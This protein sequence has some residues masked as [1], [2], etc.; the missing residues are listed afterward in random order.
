VKS[1]LF[2]GT[3]GLSRILVL[4]ALA[5]GAGLSRSDNP[6]AASWTSGGIVPWIGLNGVPSAVASDFIY[7]ESLPAN[8]TAWVETTVPGS[9]LLRFEWG[10]PETS[11]GSLE[12]ELDGIVQSRLTA[13]V[14]GEEQVQALPPGPHTLRWRYLNPTS[15]AVGAAWL[16]AVSFEPGLPAAAWGA[17]TGQPGLTW[18]GGG[19]QLWDISPKPSLT[20]TLFDNQ[21]HISASTA[22][23]GPAWVAYEPYQFNGGFHFGLEPTVEINGSPVFAHHLPLPARRVFVPAGAQRVTWHFRGSHSEQAVFL[24]NVVVIPTPEVAIQEAVDLTGPA[25]VNDASLP[26]TGL[27]SSGAGDDY[28]WVA[29]NP[30]QRSSLQFTTPTA[31]DLTVTWDATTAVSRWDPTI[32]LS[33]DGKSYPPSLT[34]QTSTQ[35]IGPG[36][37]QIT[38]FNPAPAPKTDGLRIY[39]I[40]FT[41]WNTVPLGDA[42]GLPG[43]TFTTG[44][45]GWW[46]GVV[47]PALA[48]EGSSL[49]Q[50]QSTSSN[51]RDSA[52]IE[53]VINGPAEVAFWWRVDNDN[54][55]VRLNLNSASFGTVKVNP[56]TPAA[57]S[58][59]TH[60]I[61]L[62]SGPQ[63]LRWSI[64][65]STSPVWLDQLRITPRA[66]LPL[67]VAA[68]L[69]G[70]A[71]T[72][73]I[74]DWFGAVDS[75]ALS[76]N[77]LIEI[78]SPALG[79]SEVRMS[80][81][82][83]GPGVLQFYWRRPASS[84]F[85]NRLTVLMDQQEAAGLS[86][87][88]AWEK[89]T[90]AIPPG[91]H[92]VTWRM[93]DPEP[94]AGF[95]DAFTWQPTPA[96]LTLAN[97]VDAI[98]VT[99]WAASGNDWFPITGEALTV[100]GTDA[101]AVVSQTNYGN[102]L[103]QARCTGA[104]TL[105]Y[106]TRKTSP[107]GY[108]YA[109]PSL[110]V[111]GLTY[112][113]GTPTTSL[114]WQEITLY[115]ANSGT[116]LL[117][118]GLLSRNTA[119]L[120]TLV[121]DQVS[122]TPGSGTLSLAVA[123]DQPRWSF[124]TGGPRPWLGIATP[125]GRGGHLAAVEM[126]PTDTSDGSWLETT[127]TGPGRIIPRINSPSQTHIG[128]LMD[129]TTAINS[130]NHGSDVPAGSHTLRW[131][132]YRF[133]PTLTATFTLDALDWYPT[134][135]AGWQ[136]HRFNGTGTP[137]TGQTPTADPD[138][139]GHSNMMEAVLGTDPL[140][141][142]LGSPFELA[143]SHNSNYRNLQFLTAPVFP[144]ELQ[145]SVEE[146]D[147]LT[148]P[149]T[150]LSQATAATGA[151]A[152]PLSSQP[153]QDSFGKSQVSANLSLS[154]PTGKKF[155]RLK[156]IKP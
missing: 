12:W 55:E 14:E 86:Q 126:L 46:S 114:E 62:G 38:G 111:N 93:A 20:G 134:T 118:W 138:G 61:Q 47:N 9:G 115:L 142:N 117:E 97:A 74:G 116:H 99:N 40:T 105:R 76:G 49:I 34:P 39:N 102:T 136:Q 130:G 110:T 21:E 153:L 132:A 4:I 139:D 150:S 87:G 154:S 26:W 133:A 41:P 78:H 10:F 73:T 75:N 19:S 77:G 22:I 82:F 109:Q 70:L 67:D 27:A 148:G 92:T 141:P 35:S 51:Q 3:G 98:G 63:T 64:T 18:S 129:D 57:F 32:D 36:A 65:G 48:R 84:S 121:L 104:G 146:A 107:F 24:G 101:I 69:P 56:S 30:G 112:P 59:G 42:A 17:A 123:L 29:L 95:L 83:T 127:V 90:I 106:R 53:T 147:S 149:W 7:I 71:F 16:D 23:T 131:T 58:E 8:G 152:Y 137:T 94:L 103:L 5:A 81:P 125:A 143:P 128:W 151:W 144:A 124:N 54:Y 50:G 1:H 72:P 28:A 108:F 44:G 113:A 155:W 60:R 119:L 43:R 25:I 140:R 88:T 6:P 100:D 145:A 80:A 45:T 37:H 33:L 120:E 79:T 52:W 89:V 96:T 156:V 13:N 135:W 68:D 85:G 11:H 31:G 122:F 66:T 91:Q 2:Q 15:L